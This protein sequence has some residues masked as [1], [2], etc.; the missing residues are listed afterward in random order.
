MTDLLI[1][2]LRPKREQ[3]AFLEVSSNYSVS[4]YYHD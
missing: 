1:G 2:V 4:A 3:R